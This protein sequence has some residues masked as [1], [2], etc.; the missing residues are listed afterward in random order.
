MFNISGN[1]KIIKRE[2][3]KGLLKQLNYSSNDDLK[4]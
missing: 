1:G 4:L 3:Y 2:I